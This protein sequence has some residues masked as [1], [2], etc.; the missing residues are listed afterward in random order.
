LDAKAITSACLQAGLVV[1]AP[2][3]GVLRLAP[4]LTV[5]EAEIEEGT[6]IL[7]AVLAEAAA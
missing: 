4:P 6:G 1:N 2:V 3:P 5:S 7:A